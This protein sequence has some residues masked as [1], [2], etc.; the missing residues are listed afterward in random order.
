MEPD[1]GIEHEQE[2][3]HGGHRGLELL[4]VLGEIETEARCRDDVDRQIAQ[5]DRRR[6]TEALE[7]RAHRCNA[8]SAA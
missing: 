7:A 5:R 6:A 1:E 3:A 8:S 4:A 2:R